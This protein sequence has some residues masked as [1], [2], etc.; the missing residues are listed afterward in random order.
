MVF[1]KC[2]TNNKAS[3]VYDLFLQAIQRYGLPSRVR[4]DQGGENILVAQHMLRHHGSERHSVLVGSSL[5]NQR[6]EQLWRDMH[7]CV[8]VTF[9][10]LFYYLEYHGLFNPID[11]VHIFALHYIYLPHINKSL[12]EFQDAWNSHKIR[13]EQGLTPSQLFTSRAL[14]LRESGISAVDFFEHVTDSYGVEEGGVT[15]YDDNEGVEV[16]PCQ[17]DLS[18]DQLDGLKE[19]VD[20][21]SVSDNFGI[22]LYEKALMFLQSVITLDSD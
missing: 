13:T 14:Q 10:R 12:H 6:I 22:D 21:L 17:L 18:E 9:Y 1:I 11:N 15:P 5:H 8:T 7:R 4:C 3:T 16:P 19:T 2:S 20:P